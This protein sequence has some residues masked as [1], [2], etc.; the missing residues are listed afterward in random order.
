MIPLSVAELVFKKFATEEAEAI[1]FNKMVEHFEEIRK[2]L[3][4]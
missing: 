1:D 3:H 4:P 2:K